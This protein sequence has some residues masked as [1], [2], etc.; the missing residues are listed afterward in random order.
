MGTLTS[1]IRITDPK[2]QE[3]NIWAGPGVN[4]RLQPTATVELAGAAAMA[5][6]RMRE[7]A[8]TY[9]VRLK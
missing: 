7:L 2:I 6:A 5:Q 9:A 4:A 3:F 1:P 8:A